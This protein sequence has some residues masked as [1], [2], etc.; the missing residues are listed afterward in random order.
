MTI[1]YQIKRSKRAVRARIVVT[2]EKVAVVAPVRMHEQ[3]IAQFVKSKQDWITD[4]MLKLQSRLHA[5]I[6]IAP[7]TYIDGALIP[8]Q[9]RHYPLQIQSS[10]LRRIKVEFDQIHF[11]VFVPNLCDDQES[12]KLALTAWFKARGKML[13]NQHVSF[14]AP[15]YQLMP[16]SCR[17]KTQKSRWGSCGA[18]NDININWLL[19][20]APPEI[21]EY[22][23]VHELCHIQVRNLSKDFWDLVGQHL[24]NFHEHRQWLTVNGASLMRGL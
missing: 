22:V 23:V 18:N 8:Y 2:A 20:L 16:R 5:N 10:Q 1:A 7:E 15:R 21:L 19:T 6:R 3:K 9:G 12:I 24:P 14:H 13:V 4:A 17:L 11:R